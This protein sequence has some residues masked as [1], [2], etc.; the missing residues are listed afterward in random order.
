MNTSIGKLGAVLAFATLILTGCGGGGGGGS[1]VSPPPPPPPPPTGGITRTGVAVAVGPITGFGSVIVNG[2]TYQTN[3]ATEFTR[4]DNPSDQDAFEIGE[5]VIVKGTI[6]DN[7][8]NAVA[9]S[10]EL[11]E[12]VKGPATSLVD[13]N[14]AI[15]MGQTVNSTA[16]TS[17]D[18][19]CG[20]VTFD[21]L[22]GLT[23]F[24][25]VE[26]Y[27]TVQAGGAIDATRIECKQPG[28]VTEFEINGIVS[29]NVP[30]TTF[31]INALQVNYSATPLI[32]NFPNGA[33]ED[34][35]P[36]EVKGAPADFSIG[37]P[38]EP[39]VLAASKV[40][41]KGN[42][43]D[44]NEGDHFEIEGFI[45]AFRGVDDFDV[46]V[47]LDTFT[48]VTDPAF[49]TF[50]GDENLLDVNVKVEVEGELDGD[51]NIFASKVE[52]K[53]STNI[54][55]TGVVDTFDPNE[56]GVIRV[57]NIRINTVDGQTRFEDKRDDDPNFDAGSVMAGDYVEARGQEIPAGEITAFVFERDD[58]DPDTELRGFVED[59]SVNG[60]DS[61]EILGVTVDTTS[62]QLV[63][64]D[65]NDSPISA[66]AF[67]SA[68]GT[69][70]VIVDVKGTETGT[71]ALQASE[72]ELEME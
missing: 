26:V 14:T 27:G 41:Y 54:R 48:V 11:D 61:F 67:W 47:G 69:G 72:L 24:F 35:Q 36:V 17:I 33:P 32:Q 20:G 25:A 9:E 39:D 68:V 4:D 63:Y 51:F 1:G 62:P 45:S 60:R 18:N 64:Q 3:A 21:D 29:G 15:V 56:P 65:D 19:N 5:T 55:V 49:T 53:T 34:G 71:T 31:M 66:D 23:G 70:G 57:L 44:G 58:L 59:D 43:L 42:R 7:N 8:A 13:L 52:I 46:R 12:I 22:T 50:E 28:E 2:V 10:V 30:A 6:D 40:E 16:T 37:N 38:G